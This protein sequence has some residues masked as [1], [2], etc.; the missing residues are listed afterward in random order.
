MLPVLPPAVRTAFVHSRAALLACAVVGVGLVLDIV[1]LG[2]DPTDPA[3]VAEAA[4]SPPATVFV[5]PLTTPTAPTPA[6]S[7]A[8]GIAPTATAPVTTAP[9]P[10]V[11][12]A[13]TAAPIAAPVASPMAAPPPAAQ[14]V[15]PAPSA[16]LPAPTPDPVP[17]TVPEPTPAATAAPTTT[18][19]PVTTVAPATTATTAAPTTTPR[20]TTAPT[21]SVTTTSVPTVEYLTYD[22]SRGAGAIVLAYTNRSQLALSS[23]TPN[24]GWVVSI[25]TNGPRTVTLKFYNTDTGQDAEWKAKIED[26]RVKVEN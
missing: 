4:A 24:P 6:P 16:P 8:V 11:L 17:A 10:Q 21:T 3:P 26:G 19:A 7:T 18:L 5:A 9:P 14:V 1:V 22:A 23:F 15:I 2:A 25:E 12:P 13:A 20:T